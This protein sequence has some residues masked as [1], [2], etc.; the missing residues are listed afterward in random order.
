VLI[1]VDPACHRALA[2]LSVLDRQIIAA[3]LAGVAGI[4][5]VHEGDPP[6]VTRARELG[7]EFQ[8]AGEVPRFRSATLLLAGNLAVQEEDLKRVLAG[9][10][11][12]Q[13]SSKT[14]LPC[15]VADSWSGDL[16]GSLPEGPRV[17]ARGVA[18]LVTDDLSAAQVEDDLW[19]TMGLDSDS[20]MDRNFNRP[21]GR[22][23]SRLLIHTRIS[24][25]VISVVAML[26][27]VLAAWC[28]SRGTR[29]GMILGAIV[30]QVS[31]VADCV[32]GDL[33]RM[34]HKESAVGKWL[35]FAGGQLVHLCLFAGMGA[36]LYQLNGPTSPALWLG[37]AAVLGMVIAFVIVL[38]AKQNPARHPRLQS[39]IQ[40]TAHRDFTLILLALAI[41]NRVEW[42]LWAGAIGVNGF[43]LLALGLQRKDRPSAGRETA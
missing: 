14:P 13:D 20:L 1:A 30:L 40:K 31:G 12:L 33:A 21:L 2:V 32:D 24:P 43:W 26:I 37:L 29:E 35:D 18:R 28:F 15:G 39:L 9:N 23:L 7:I 41:A 25:N 6:P 36:G 22:P 17:T 10:G 8:M 27:G 16:E 5:V 11:R 3:H 38:R 19:D 42:F 34:M 4:T